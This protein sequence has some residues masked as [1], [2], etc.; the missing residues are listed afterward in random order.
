MYLQTR[1]AIL[2]PWSVADAESVVRHGNNPRIAACMRDGFPHPYTL[3]DANRFIDL[4][5]ST[6]NLMLAIEVNGEAAGGIGI[7]Y[8]EDVYRGTGEI[9]YWL[10]ES[11]WGQGI[12]TDAVRALVPAVFRETALVRIQAGI[13]ANNKASARV[14]EKCGFLREA[15]HKNAITKDGV[16]MDEIVYAIL[17]KDTGESDR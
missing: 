17:K 12:V 5:G 2:R 14:L 7:H 11:F 16:L 9:G 6:K 1:K 13:F 3:A 10:S 15:V 8:F 4:A